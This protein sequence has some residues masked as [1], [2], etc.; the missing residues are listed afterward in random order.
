MA[1]CF[2]KL[3]ALDLEIEATLS[4]TATYCGEE[5]ATYYDNVTINYPIDV[6]G[7]SYSAHELLELLGAA[8]VDYLEKAILETA[9]KGDFIE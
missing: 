6:S 2:V 9:E 4:A 1:T 7:L 8:A 3:T 5:R